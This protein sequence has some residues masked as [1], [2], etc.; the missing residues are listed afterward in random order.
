MDQICHENVC[1]CVPHHVLTICEVISSN[2]S[3]KFCVYM[4]LGFRVDDWSHFDNNF[5]RLYN[6]KFH[7]IF[8]CKLCIVW[9][10]CYIPQSMFL[11][12]LILML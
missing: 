2:M 7:Y 10:P 1:V 12:Y 9:Y 8:L 6:Q 5:M 4:G 11:C 3:W